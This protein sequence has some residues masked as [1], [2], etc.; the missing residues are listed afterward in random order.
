MENKE[1][2]EP[3]KTNCTTVQKEMLPSKSVYFMYFG[4]L[5]SFLPFSN[6]F[7][8]SVGLTSDEAGFISGLSHA[9]SAIGCPLWGFLADW[10]NQRSLIFII[11][12]IGSAVT[13][14][15]KPFVAWKVNIEQQIWCR[16]FEDGNSQNISSARLPWNVSSDNALRRR[17]VQN[18][19]NQ[20]YL[21]SNI[22]A[23]SSLLFRRVVGDVDGDM[24]DCTPPLVHF[25]SVLFFVNLILFTVAEIFYTSLSGIVDSFIMVIIKS[26]NNKT[27]F[28]PQR[29]FGS[30][31]FAITSLSSGLAA[32]DFSHPTLSKYTPVFCISLPFFILLI[33]LG[34]VCIRQMYN[35][36]RNE[37]PS[38]DAV[39][40]AHDFGHDCAKSPTHG[41][42]SNKLS[43]LAKTFKDLRNIFFFLS[44][45]VAGALDCV[46]QSF[47]F[48]LM[49]DDMHASKTAM[50]VAILVACIS[51]IF[52]FPLS[53]IIIKK[54]GS[55]LTCIELGIVSHGIRLLVLSYCENAWASIPIH[56]LHSVTWALLW[57]AQVE[58]IDLVTPAPIHSTMF[59]LLNGMYFGVPSVFGNII[60]G[61]LYYR[62]GGQ[63]LFKSAA[64]LAGVWAI[65]M[66][67]CFHVLVVCEPK[68]VAT[69]SGTDEVELISMPPPPPYENGLPPL[70]DKGDQR[71]IV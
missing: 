69:D 58:Y 42:S 11:L 53:S 13:V 5:G 29:V 35:I 14:A 70:T 59:G 2:D 30:V 71:T 12:C 37:K 19:L 34:L 28:G 43:L 4:G 31:A 47:L 26:R 62:Y 36:N 63:M 40:V 52:M 48:M 51:E 22:S 32:D 23:P 15:A 39:I 57:A 24:V 55:P 33:P 54:V 49:D 60:G 61:V 18:H 68:V 16:N 8:V 10:T 3:M 45:F 9:F 44:V 25:N 41:N 6:I 1:D 65:I 27:G 64:C 67:V 56:V 46:L 17:G 38:A 7:L 66:F 20:T 50:G 21:R